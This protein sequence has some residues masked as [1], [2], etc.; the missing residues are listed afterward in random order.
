MVSD[1]ICQFMKAKEKK[2][3]VLVIGLIVAFYIFRPDKQQI[4]LGILALG[5]LVFV[6][7]IFHII[8]AR[9][10]VHWPKVHGI[11]RRSEVVKT[12]S[13]GSSTS[14]RRTSYNFEVEY[15]YEVNGQVYS[16][17]KY[18]Y[19]VNYNA[20]KEKGARELSQ[21]YPVEALVDV[22]Y[23]SKKPKRSVLL[24]GINYASYLPLLGGIIFVA[25]GC[26]IYLGKM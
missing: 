11:I 13:S 1:I 24:P 12:K 14:H 8:W 25:A 9:A 16:N 10:S 6:G 3:S 7:G 23:D 4:G 15:E 26:A 18:S 22:Y 21:R 5:L 17:N 20:A 19:L 2:V